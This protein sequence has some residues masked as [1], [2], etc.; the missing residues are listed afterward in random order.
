MLKKFESIIIIE[1]ASLKDA[2]KKIDK[3]DDKI[4]FVVDSQN[5]LKGSLSDG[6]IRRWILSGGNLTSPVSEASFKNTYFVKENYNSENVKKEFLKRI[7]TTVPVVDNE[8][9]ITQF[10]TW[11]QLHKS[12]F[13]KV[14]K[15]KLNTSVVIMAGGKGTRLDPFTRILPKPLIPIGDKTILEIIIEKFT[16]F[17]IDQFYISVNHKARIIKSYFEE[18]QP[19]Y[20]LKYLEEDK[21]LGTVGALSKLYKVEEGNILLTNC[22][23]IIDTD[24]N[25]LLNHHIKEKNDITLV[26]SM[27]QYSV[28]YGICKI[29]NGGELIEIK[30]KPELDFLINTGMYI[31]K[32]EV[33]KHIPKNEFYHITHLIDKIK[34]LGCKVGIYPVSEDSWFDTGEWAEYKK[35]VNK[36]EL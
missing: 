19:D 8:N 2:M 26:A 5:M 13:V 24:Y 32:S 15:E 7:I 16:S 10:L 25:D 34:S 18:L 1:K 9:R 21:P 31:L 27:K 11:D 28:P 22:D 36:I 4:V 3:N 14:V 30:E 23:I 29:K 20:K 33:L 6:D 35:T 17:K 12:K